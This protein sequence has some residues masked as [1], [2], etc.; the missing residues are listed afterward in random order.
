MNIKRFIQNFSYTLIAN[1]LSVVISTVLILIVPKF[2]SVENYG[3]WQLYI[4]YSSFI[5]YMSLGLTDGA[6]LRYGGYE[7]KNLHKPVFVS[8]YWFLVIFNVVVN[9]SIAFVYGMNST[10]PNKSIVVLLTCLTGILVVPRSLLTFMLQSTNRIKEYSIITILER[11]VYFG[12]VILFLL[13]GINKF[14]YLILADILGKVSSVIYACVVSKDLVFGKFES[15]KNLIREIGIN[16]SVGSKLLIANFASLLI[17][18]IVRFSIENNWSVETFGKVSLT[19]S[20]SNMLML[21]INAVGLILF[22]ALRRTAEDKLPDIYRLMRTIIMVPLIGILIFYYPAKVLLSSWLPQ[23]AESFIYMA[24]LFPMCIFESKTLMLINTYLKTLRKEKMLLI[25]NLTTVVL[26]FGLAYINVFLLND[27]NLSV[28][29]ITL[30]LAFR[31]II[32]EIYLSKV[33]HIKV[34]RDIVLEVSMTLVFIIVSWYFEIR[35][36]LIVYFIAYILYLVL[37]K[38]DITYFIK[39]ARNILNSQK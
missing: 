3:Y 29:S 31:S 34:K 17:I 6:Y 18:G 11:I 10:D 35:I 5:S 1:L 27:L 20:I 28:F 4:F 23:Y 7:Y 24:L 19:L 32:A 39:N 38:S 2:I 8:Q 26:S 21:F 30:L 16:I 36:A 33:L 12:L 13:F 25:I 14:E 9:F 22:P 15:I 37:K